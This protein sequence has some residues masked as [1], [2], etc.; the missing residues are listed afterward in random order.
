[1]INNVDSGKSG[2]KG[3]I[4]LDTSL[5][6][7]IYKRKSFHIFMNV[8]ND[9]VSEDEISDIYEAY[10]RFT[11]LDENIKTEIRVVPAGSTSCRRG[12]E[13]CILMYSEKKEGY[14]QNIGFLG[15]Q[16]DLYLVSKNIGTLWFGVGKTDE[17]PSDPELEYVIMF[18][19]KKI[20]DM[21]KYRKDMFKSKRKPNEEIWKGKLI[22]GVSDIVGFA[23]SACNSQPW[24]VENGD[25]LTV[26]RYKKPGK[27]G[28]MPADKVSFYNRIDIGIF[29]CFL[30]L[31]LSKNEIEYQRELFVD[32][33][34]D[35]ELTLNAKYKLKR[36]GGHDGAFI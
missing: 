26:Y 1:M 11:P 10:R 7:M 33:G 3:T 13:Y 16:L 14:L 31:C 21:S 6:E 15:E 30:E 8:G 5:Y 2:K 12:E 32:D 9:S 18:A 19:I 27:R 17:A 20:S 34:G 36:S 35:I 4:I 25:E 29:L 24:F 22:E 28:I 23:P